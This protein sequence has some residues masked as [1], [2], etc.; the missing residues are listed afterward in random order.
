MEWS[1][2]LVL[3]KRSTASTNPLAAKNQTIPTSNT[4]LQIQAIL[5]YYAGQAYVK[6]AL[7]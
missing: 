4:L 2:G 6:G 5:A 3:G 1:L 7:K